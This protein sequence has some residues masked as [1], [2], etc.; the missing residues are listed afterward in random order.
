MKSWTRGLSAALAVCVLLLAG[1]AGCGSSGARG[2]TEGESPAPVGRLLDRT[3]EEG[4][5]YREVDGKG[6]PEVGVEVQ[7]DAGG[8]W[9]VR[10]TVRRF[11]FS[12]AGT[13]ARASAGRG[14]A[15]LLVDGRLVGRLRAPEYRLSARLVPRGTH[16]VTA[17][18]YADDGTVW[19]VAGKAVQSTADI[20]AAPPAAP[21]P[22]ATASAT[23][24][25][26]GA[27]A[28][29]ASPAGRPR[30]L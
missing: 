7:P 21:A 1:P 10:L 19:A 16:H 5:R 12:P 29:T 27:R 28:A 24:R 6:A 23:A 30:P 4:R 14:L 25:T 17:R 18:L 15:H 9:D 2:H 26:P 11:R 22:T 8:N 13:A 20:T 3:D